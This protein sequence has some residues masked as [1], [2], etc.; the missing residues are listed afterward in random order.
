[1]RTFF[2]P[3]IVEES[4]TLH[5]WRRAWGSSPAGK[6]RP[7]LNGGEPPIARVA[8]ESL[9]LVSEV[10]EA[11]HQLVSRIRS[12]RI[13]VSV[14][15]S[16]RHGIVPCGRGGVFACDR[17]AIRYRADSHARVGGRVE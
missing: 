3:A 7:E 4:A 17:H 10:A 9:Q 1:M 14:D 2:E 5:L 11:L 8:E 12:V 6:L 13:V 16:R 15:P